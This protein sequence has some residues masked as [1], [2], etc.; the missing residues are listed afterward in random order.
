M[1][2]NAVSN[3]GGCG[4]AI[5]FGSSLVSYLCIREGLL[6]NPEKAAP[7]PPAASVVIS[8]PGPPSG[9]TD[10]FSAYNVGEPPVVAAANSTVSATKPGDWM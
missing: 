10:N 2:N 5:V 1:F 3:F 4:L 6:A 7:G 9:F 8:N